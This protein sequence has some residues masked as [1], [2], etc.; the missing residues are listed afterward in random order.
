MLTDSIALDQGSVDRTWTT[1]WPIPGFDVRSG[2][3]FSIPFLRNALCAALLAGAAAGA[4]A[5]AAAPASKAENQLQRVLGSGQLRV[6]IWPDYYGITYRNPKTRLLSGID[7]DIATELGRELGVR[8]RYID[9]SFPMLVVKPP[10]SRENEVESGRADAFMTDYPYGK[11]M[12]D[13]TGWA[14]MVAPPRSFHLTDYAYALA[15]GDASLKE[16]VDRFMDGIK[17]DGRLR[18]FARKHRLEILIRDG[19]GKPG[20]QAG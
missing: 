20:Q 9:S 7:I 18:Q 19:A 16:R 11:R 4:A 12:L 5:A 2:T 3:M 1:R 13:M 10:Q 15:P 14:R 17:A 6:C 8:I